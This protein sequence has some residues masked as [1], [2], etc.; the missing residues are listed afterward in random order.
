MA[1]SPVVPPLVSIEDHDVA[2]FATFEAL[3]AYVEPPDVPT[4]TWDSRGRR[5]TLGIEPRLVTRR[6]PLLRPYEQPF[7]T[8]VGS[9]SDPAHATELSARLRIFLGRYAGPAPPEADLQALIRLVVAAVGFTPSAH[10]SRAWTG[11]RRRS[12][13]S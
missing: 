4:P 10:G 6:L 7:V 9:D 3:T 13:D 5:L 11:R 12:P 8:V 1:G 2:I